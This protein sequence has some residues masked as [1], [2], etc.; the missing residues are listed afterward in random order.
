MAQTEI[1][2]VGGR[3]HEG[4]TVPRKETR[5]MLRL[6]PDLHATLTKLAEQDQRSLN[7]EIVFLLDHI[8]QIAAADNPTAF[9]RAV[10]RIRAALLPIIPE[11]R[12]GMAAE[13]AA[14]VL[15]AALD[16]RPD[17]IREAPP[18]GARGRRPEAASPNGV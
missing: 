16:D 2:I 3:P 8:I 17:G 6:P 10:R 18:S 12:Q 4:N 11:N 1:R 15:R 9:S 14:D 13:E 5:L 7:G